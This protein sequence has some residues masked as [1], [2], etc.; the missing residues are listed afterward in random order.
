MREP[1]QGILEYCSR[2]FRF[3]LNDEQIS[4]KVNNVKASL[5]LIGVVGYEE[6]NDKN[7]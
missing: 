5:N 7:R 2:V 3:G 1:G 6:I 4:L